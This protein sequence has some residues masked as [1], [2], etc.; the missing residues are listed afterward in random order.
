MRCSWND[1]LVWT[2]ADSKIGRDGCDRIEM[3]VARG[4]TL[5]A[6]I[7]VNDAC[8]AAAIR[9]A[10]ASRT[11]ESPQFF[12][13]VDV[14]VEAN[15]GLKCFTEVESGRNRFATRRAP[16]RVYDA[17]EPIGRSLA[18]SAAT[19]AVRVHIPIAAD[20]K[21]GRREY[22]VTV[23]HAGEQHVLKL[24]ATV[25]RAVI[26][27]V[28]RDSWPYTN[29]FS[30]ANMASFHGVKPWTEGHWSMIRKYAELMARNRQNMFLV[31]F[32]DI[33]TADKSG[34]TLN[35]ERFR[36]IVK[37]FTQ[38]GMYYI[39]GG[40]FG[41]RSK[42][43]FKCPTFSVALTKHIA[44]SPEGNAAIAGAAKQLMS[45]IQRNGWKDRYLQHVADEP[46]PENR[47]EY[48]MFVGMVR[49][50]MPGIPIAD[51]T[52]D[53]TL[54]G[55]VDIWCPQGVE[56]EKHREEFEAMRALGDRVWYYT[57]CFPGGPY[58]NRL[59]DME[60]LRPALMGWAGALYRLDGFLHWGLNQYSPKIDP[61]KQ[62][63]VLH[64][65]YNNTLPAGDTHVVYPG[66]GAPWSSAR[67]ES[68]RE[69]IEDLELL[70]LLEQRQPRRAASIVQSVIRGFGDFTKDMR[71]FRSARRK[72][73][74]SLS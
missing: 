70:R 57:C 11:G 71:V 1:S 14:P 73:L 31:S 33:F 52:M 66:E 30:F 40:H 59:M 41:G 15:T 29:W 58:L 53:T 9:L 38:A 39:E 19:Q 20:A 48:R 60:L 46:I 35:R 37:V 42:A 13:L 28:G 61:L 36:R 49:K 8:P 6:T 50:Y 26:P 25:Y 55:S 65:C 23:S 17:I 69:G 43:D 21:P 74:E 16:F 2:Y 4:G 68:Q 62:S 34:L 27:P 32:G 45:E 12:R 44:T 10:V 63:I 47:A 7:L 56:Y 3:D 51:A 54:T 18:A 67:L 64:N 22:L 24:A 72:V 5:A